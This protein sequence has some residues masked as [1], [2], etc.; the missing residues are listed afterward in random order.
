MRIFGLLAISAMLFSAECQEIKVALAGSSAC[1]GYGNTDPKL[2]W[3]W[4]E[5]IGEYFK[6]GVVILNHAKSGRSSKSFIA[7]GLWEKL[8]A[9]RPDYIFMTLG[10]NDTKGKKDATDPQ[11]E[12]KDNLRRFASDADKIGA[13]IIFITL[14]TSL[15]SGPDKDKA[16]FDRKTGR[17]IRSDRLAYCQAM[18]EVA[19]ELK[20]PCLELFDNQVLEWEA[21]GEEK[22][23]KL[24]RYNPQKERIDSSHTNKEG[25]KRI[26]RII[27][28]ELTKS[29]SPLATWVNIAKLE[30][31]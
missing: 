7:Q 20:K 22:A 3:G 27:M 6:P 26:A 8:L 11:T 25:A 13:Q 18:R 23:G 12:Y 19:A 17:P 29:S 9:E 30:K 16:Y 1:Q 2:I 4:G 31:E 28:R 5:V 24:Y 15:V 14:N 21:L 10:A